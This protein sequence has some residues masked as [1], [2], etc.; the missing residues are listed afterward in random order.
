MLGMCG[1]MTMAPDDERLISLTTCLRPRNSRTA[2][3]ETA[4]WRASPRS[5]MVR[6]AV[7][8]IIVPS[9]KKLDAT[10]SNAFLKLESPLNLIHPRLRIG[11]R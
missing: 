3:L 10:Y 4:E 9:R 5:S 7:L 1:K 2:V 8:G 6:I 11:L